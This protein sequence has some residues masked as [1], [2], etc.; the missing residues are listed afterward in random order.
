MKKLLYLIQLL[1]IISIGCENVEKESG[2]A[3]INGSKIYY[4]IAG[5][6]EPLVLIHGWSFDTRCWDDQFDIFAK[7]Y[8]V[9]RYD[10]RGFGRSDLPDTSINYSHTDDLVSLLNYL[11]INK[12]HILGHSFGGKIAFDF[13]FNYPEKTISLILPDAAMDVPGLEVPKDVS[14]WIRNTWKAG[15]EQGIEDAKKVWITGSPLKPAMNNPL[16]APKVRKMIEDYSGWHW[17]ND[18]PCIYPKS[19]PPTRLS[20]IKIPT[21]IIVGELN[22]KIYH[23]WADIQNKYILNSKKEVLPNAGHALNIENPL[24]FNEFVLSFLS[25]IIAE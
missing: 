23:D 3:E 13:V 21:L 20:E 6:G 15:R 2:L 9:L 22:P 12:A 24:K 18:D 25:E 5:I 17:A 4:E 14:D 11:H 10:L 7:K 8:R 16:S 19:F 1:L